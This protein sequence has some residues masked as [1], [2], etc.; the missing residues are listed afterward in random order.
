M[1]DEIKKAT[2][3]VDAL[4]AGFEQFKAANDARLAEI[5]K[6]GSADALLDEKIAASR[7]IST[8]LKRRPMRPL[9]LPSAS[10]AW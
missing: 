10:R 1:S 3:A 2:E 6:K 7:P 4:H 9:L 5:E 8:S